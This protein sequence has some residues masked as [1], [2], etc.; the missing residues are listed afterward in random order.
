MGVVM[1]KRIKSKRL[2][3]TVR[4]S[5][6]DMQLLVPAAVAMGMISEGGIAD[7][8]SFMKWA[9][10]SSAKGVLARKEELLKKGLE[11]EQSERSEEQSERSEEQ[12]ESNEEPTKEIADEQEIRQDIETPAETEQLQTAD[13]GE[14]ES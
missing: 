9:A 12:S 13:S 11:Q 6:Q 2:A 5:N 1:S 3:V 14:Q 8:K 10:L 7:L 4:I